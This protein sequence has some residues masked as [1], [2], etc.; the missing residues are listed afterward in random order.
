MDGAAKQPRR[1]AAHLPPEVLARVFAQLRDPVLICG[2]ARVAKAW[3]YA[4]KNPESWRR[5]QIGP[6]VRAYVYHHR[7]LQRAHDMAA[8][9][10]RALRKLRLSQLLWAWRISTPSWVPPAL[11]VPAEWKTHP[12]S[13]CWLGRGYRNTAARALG[14]E[15]SDVP[16]VKLGIPCEARFSL[17]RGM[18]VP[19]L[20]LGYIATKL[21]PGLGFTQPNISYGPKELLCGTAAQFES[22][23]GV[24]YADVLQQPLRTWGVREGSW[25][26]VDD[27]A[28]EFKRSIMLTQA[29]QPSEA[30]CCFAVLTDPAAMRRFHTDQGRRGVQK[31]RWE[32]KEWKSHRSW[33]NRSWETDPLPPAERDIAQQTTLCCQLADAVLRRIAFVPDATGIGRGIPRLRLLEELELDGTGVSNQLLW[34]IACQDRGCGDQYPSHTSSLACL[35]HVSFKRFKINDMC[36]TVSASL[37]IE[38]RQSFMRLILAF[39]ASG[40]GC[41]L[42]SSTTPPVSIKVLDPSDVYVWFKMRWMTPLSKM[43]DVFAQRQGGS[44]TL[45]SFCFNGQPVRGHDTA[46]DLG[47]EDDDEII[48]SI[49]AAV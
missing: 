14:G 2:V 3:S 13:Y 9:A 42:D 49:A 22:E 38:S 4:S 27:D 7:T 41:L 32:H 11:A 35:R 29:E 18:A 28:S 1:A 33:E 21:L 43:M 15:P 5:A 25:L 26:D 44:T 30:A 45:Y 20:T 24:A 40:V 39:R 46:F 16:D 19:D 36:R 34:D 8:A 37:E 48:A 47:M 12:S 6:A 10:A 31:A 23:R 17:P